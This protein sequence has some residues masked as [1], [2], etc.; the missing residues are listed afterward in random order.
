M[1]KNSRGQNRA[2][3]FKYMGT[4]LP[5][6]PL[7]IFKFGGLYLRIK[8]QSNKAGKRFK[9]ELIKQGI[10]KQRA[11]ELTSIYLQPADLR[12]YMTNFI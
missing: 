7:L 6:L 11:N 9:K 10:D 8:N 12:S 2:N 4:F 3:G 1:A 5:K